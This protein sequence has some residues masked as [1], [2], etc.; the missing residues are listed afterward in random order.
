MLFIFRPKGGLPAYL[1]AMDK[2]NK[3]MKYFS[4]V[5]HGGSQVDTV[6]GVFLPYSF[7]NLCKNKCI[8]AKKLIFNSVKVCGS[9]VKA[10]FSIFL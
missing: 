3:S 10:H 8:F 2:L 7:Y 5:N 6:V 1:E 4:H 9:Q